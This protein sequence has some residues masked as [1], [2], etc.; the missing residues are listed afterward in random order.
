MTSSNCFWLVIET[1]CDYLKQDHMVQNGCEKLKAGSYFLLKQAEINS[2]LFLI[3][4]ENCCDYLK[5]EY[6]FQNGCD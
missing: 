6:I 1:G 5:Q 4:V 3:V 2:N